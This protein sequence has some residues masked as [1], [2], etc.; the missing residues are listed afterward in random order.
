MTWNRTLVKEDLRV[1][2]SSLCICFTVL[3]EQQNKGKNRM[4]NMKVHP[5]AL[6]AETWGFK[7]GLK[8]PES[9][10]LLYAVPKSPME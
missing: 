4:R 8:G 6:C 1:G 3:E 9:N 2:S 10:V 7:N 5:Q